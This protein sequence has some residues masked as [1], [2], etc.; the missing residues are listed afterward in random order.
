MTAALAAL[1]LIPAA[2][3]KAIGSESQRP[4]AVVIVGGTV[5]A[6]VLTLFVMPVM[7]R[8]LMPVMRRW[9]GLGA[10]DEP[11]AAQHPA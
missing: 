7:Y 2:M 8:V 10:P 11:P 4:I 5:S 1:G 9:G 3:S 6:A